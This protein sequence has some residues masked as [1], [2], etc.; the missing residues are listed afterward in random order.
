MEKLK[1]LYDEFEKIKL[2]YIGDKTDW[3]QKEK[4]LDRLYYKANH[5]K[6]SHSKNSCFYGYIKTKLE[7]DIF[8]E[9]IRVNKKNKTI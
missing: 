8:K 9:W 2:S 6:L 7:T 1:Q 4:E 5:L 3:K